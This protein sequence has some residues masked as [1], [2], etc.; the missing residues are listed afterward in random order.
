[1][2]CINNNSRVVHNKRDGLGELPRDGCLSREPDYEVNESLPLGYVLSVGVVPDPEVQ[3]GEVLDPT[4]LLTE[5]PRDAFV[6]LVTL[7]DSGFHRIGILPSGVSPSS[8][9]SPTQPD[10]RSLQVQDGTRSTR[11]WEGLS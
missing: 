7:T 3:L 11:L 6:L 8:W 2:Y 9:S 5:G 4:K 10:K 1:M